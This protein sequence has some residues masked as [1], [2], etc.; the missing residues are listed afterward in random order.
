MNAAVRAATLVATA[1]GWEVYG[2]RHGYQGL[3]A[4]ELEPLGPRDVQRIVREGGTMLGSARCKAFHEQ[5]TRDRARAVLAARGISGLVVIG[6]NGSLA[7]A[8]ALSDPDEAGEHAPRVVGIPASIDNDLAL[9]SLSIGADTA[10]N[11]IVEA[12]DKIA[13]TASAHDRTFLVEVMGRECG[14][15]AMTSAVA[16]GADLVLFPEAERSDEELVAD[17]VRAVAAVRKRAVRDR[18]VIAIT[19]EGVRLPTTELKRRVDEE[20]A[21]RGDPEHP[22]ETRVTVLGHVV[23]GGRPS[24]FDR[25]LGS[26]LANVAVRALIAGRTRVMVAWLPPSELPAEIAT[27]SADDPYCFVV[28]LPAVLRATEQL[29]DGEGELAQ[30]RKA[31]FNQLETVLTL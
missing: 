8:L 4:D 30:W 12:C 24:A 26:R 2:V 13:D 6:G 9:T 17:V 10:M 3:I 22:V 14:Y 31:V 27:R 15:L 23:R 21:R 18:R 16:A 19:A 7:G 5:A 20:L 11:T 1:A 29:L 25:L 28:D